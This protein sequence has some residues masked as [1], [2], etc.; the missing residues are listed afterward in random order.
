MAD[1]GNEIS[2]QKKGDRPRHPIAWYVI[3]SLEDWV[4]V[5]RHTKELATSLQPQFGLATFE[6]AFERR[7]RLNTPLEGCH[8]KHINHN[9]S[10]SANTPHPWFSSFSPLC[11]LI[12]STFFLAFLSFLSSGIT[13][14]AA[15][16]SPYN[17]QSW[18]TTDRYNISHK[19]G[20]FALD[21]LS[22]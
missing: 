16:L 4:Y 14:L 21:M 10:S 20:G 22:T 8:C 13:F 11:P 6:G 17:R 12:L 15:N 1:T 3:S 7:Q 2:G 19:Y 18:F 9:T 5:L